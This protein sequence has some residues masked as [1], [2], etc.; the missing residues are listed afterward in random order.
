M[1][2]DNAVAEKER[3]V[4]SSPVKAKSKKLSDSLVQNITG[5]KTSSPEKEF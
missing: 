4:E 1:S 2:N 3:D 5:Q